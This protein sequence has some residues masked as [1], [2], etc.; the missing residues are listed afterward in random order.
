MQQSEGME[1]SDKQ[2]RKQIKRFF[3]TQLKK[4]T[5]GPGLGRMFHPAQTPVADTS[6]STA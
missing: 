1:D 3:G 5:L 2:K 4:K 6:D